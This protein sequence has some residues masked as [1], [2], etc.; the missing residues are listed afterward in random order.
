MADAN[1]TDPKL[2]TANPA[3]PA[4]G[5]STTAPADPV[6]SDST[7]TPAS[8]SRPDKPTDNKTGPVR[9]PVLDLK[10]RASDSDTGK[11]GR[12]KSDT[13]A[14]PG[15]TTARSAGIPGASAAPAPAAGR[16]GATIGAAAGGGLLGLAAAYGLALAGLWPAP[17]LP[18]PAPAPEDP[19]LAQFASAIPE[20]ETV[21]QTTQSELMA[22]NRRIA[23]LES[24]EPAAPAP[25]AAPTDLSG[26]EAEIAALQTRID[27]LGAQPAN[28]AAP[29]AAAPAAD[30]AATDALRTD[31]AALNQRVEQLAPLAQRVDELGTLPEQVSQLSALPAQVEQLAAL[32]PRL[33]EL[34][35]R[36]GTTEAN[37]RNLDTTVAQ[38]SATLAEQPADIGAV[39]Q[40]PLILSGLEAAFGS[41]RPYEAELAALR[42]AVPSLAVPLPVANGAAAGLLRPDQVAQRFNAALPAIL[43][44]RPAD[45]EAGWAQGALGW[46]RSAVAIRPTGEREGDDPEAVV[47][48]LESAIARRDWAAAEPLFAALP[49]PMRTAAGDVPALV[50]T[51]AE[52]ARFLDTLR[53]QALSGEAAS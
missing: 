4:P 29:S 35:A 51:Q 33:D 12:G 46:L 39:L 44:G 48:R 32:Q 45:P 23:E 42:N 7:T 27:E 16:T 24:V 19:R 2:G 5:D 21:T 41:G 17:E 3:D 28:P 38:T 37:L 36:L 31:L 47:T 49:E 18:T 15:S 25:A 11:A 40:L 53:A 10:P 22:L 52:A 26:I 30:P 8:A 20:L 13:K 34:A 6:A 1:D 9:P 43:A 14:T 50:S